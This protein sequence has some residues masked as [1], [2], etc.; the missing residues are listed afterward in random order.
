MLIFIDKYSKINY[1]HPEHMTTSVQF[2]TKNIEN[3][4]WDDICKSAPKSMTWDILCRITHFDWSWA[5][6]C[7]RDDAIKAKQYV[8]K[9][10]VQHEMVKHWT[11]VTGKKKVGKKSQQT[12]KHCES[13]CPGCGVAKEPLRELC[14]DCA[15]ISQICPNC[16]GKKSPQYTLCVKCMYNCP[17]CGGQKSPHFQLCAKCN[18][19]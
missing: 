19:M 1:L 4:T 17:S 8:P 9:P 15:T 6:E 11:V 14:R 3:M 13:K 7:D 5:D 16:N 2:G 18:H 12:R 10:I